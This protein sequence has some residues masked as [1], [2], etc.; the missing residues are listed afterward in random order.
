MQYGI[1]PNKSK[2]AKVVLVCKNCNQTKATKYR[3]TL[4]LTCFSKRIEKL[5]YAK[6]IIFSKNIMSF[7]YSKKYGFQI[8]FSTT[9]AI[10]D[11]ITTI[12]DNIYKN[13]IS[14]LLLINL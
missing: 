11:V 5:K 6:F 1:Y 9:H 2:I 13:L 12:Y 4:I 14:S 7:I 10:L 3:I 8:K